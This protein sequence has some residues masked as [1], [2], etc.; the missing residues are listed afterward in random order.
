MTEK[1]EFSK[2]PVI[3]VVIGAQFNGGILNTNL[4]YDFYQKIK[5]D[6]PNIQEQPPLPSVIE[7]IEE[8]NQTRILQGFHSRRFFINPSGDKLIQL[9]PDKLLFNWRK[10]ADS[11]EYPKFESVLENFLK[12]FGLIQKDVPNLKDTINQLELTFVDHIFVKDF[13]LNYYNLNEIFNHFTLPY[14]LKTVDSTFAIPKKEL[15]GSLIL[16]IKSARS[17]KDQSKLIVCETTCRG[18]KNATES[19]DDW[20]NRAHSILVDFFLNL[21]N[22]KSKKIWGI[23]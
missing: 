13:G 2:P 1:V 20:Y 4:I 22:D 21:F 23:K 19:V 16:S 5:T 8:G 7:N 12:V 11:S 18:I 14:D 6:F 9:Q 15:S 3:E 10:M 17:N